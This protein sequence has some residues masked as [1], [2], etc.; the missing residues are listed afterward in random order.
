[1]DINSTSSSFPSEH[2]EER[3]ISSKPI[4]TSTSTPGP[5]TTQRGA[6]VSEAGPNE[7]TIQSGLI[8]EQR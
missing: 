6:A 1:M 3:D 5:T 7:A 2:E 8:T 4:S